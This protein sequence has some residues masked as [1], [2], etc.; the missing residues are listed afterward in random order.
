MESTPSSKLQ[1]VIQVRLT[2][3]VSRFSRVLTGL[4]EIREFFQAE[5]DFWLG[6]KSKST[7]KP[8]QQAIEIYR[9]HTAIVLNK[10]DE[11]EHELVQKDEI[12]RVIEELK[13]ICESPLE[14][15]TNYPILYSEMPITQKIASMLTSV[16]N[17]A[18]AAAKYFGK[19]DDELIRFISQRGKDLLHYFVDVAVLMS[20]DF[21]EDQLFTE[22]RDNLRDLSRRYERKIAEFSDHIREAIVKNSELQ[23]Q[24]NMLNSDL[25]AS[26]ESEIRDF[27]DNFTKQLEKGKADLQNL[28]KA[29]EEHLHLSEP[30]VHWD[31]VSRN[32]RGRGKRWVAAM[33]ASIL[34]AVLLL[35]ALLYWPSE[36]LSAS[37]F[38]GDPKAIKGII[39]FATLISFMAYLSRIMAKLS[40]SSFHLQRDADERR[41]LTTYYLSLI[42]HGDVKDSERTL[43]I[44][45]LFKR[46]DTGLLSDA[47]QAP[48]SFSI[49]SILEQLKRK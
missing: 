3:T 30:A 24:Y 16:T 35:V 33:I 32:Y 25:V 19:P 47:E 23:Q 37:L 42:K 7:I 21:R 45:A 31:T 10:L 5:S 26:K 27:K 15:N 2:T 36:L 4:D 34:C 48:S 8:A 41:A 49:A 12:P 20:D 44:E 22:E 6:Q 1:D 11:I 38:A 40:I 43:I 9:N 28:F 18:H 46:S 39:I 14:T 29:Y 13:T 17:E